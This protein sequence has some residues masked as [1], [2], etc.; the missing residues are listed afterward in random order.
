MSKLDFLHLRDLRFREKFD[1]IIWDLEPLQYAWKMEL[2]CS[3]V[4]KQKKTQHKLIEKTI[5]DVV[6]DVSLAILFVVLFT[7]PRKT[8]IN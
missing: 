5:N 6:V 2:K 4:P 1:S 7:F 8:S 3:H